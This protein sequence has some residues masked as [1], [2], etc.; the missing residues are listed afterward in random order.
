MNSKEF[1]EAVGGISNENITKYAEVSPVIVKGKN[2]KENGQKKYK[3][4]AVGAAAA[5]MLAAGVFAAVH[6]MGKTP[7]PGQHSVYAPTVIPT[8]NTA[9]EAAATE[10]PP[11]VTDPV[12]E[13]EAISTPKITPDQSTPVPTIDPT[14][15]P[16][17]TPTPTAEPTVTPMPTPTPFQ[18]TTPPA[19]PTPTPTVPVPTDAPI[20]YEFIS[21]EQL[22]NM[23]NNGVDFF[24]EI[25][26]Y[27]KPKNFPSGYSL[28]SIT[29]DNSGI[30]FNYSNGEKGCS[31]LWFWNVDPDEL[32][33]TYQHAPHLEHHGRY[34]RFYDDTAG[35][36]SYCSVVW[37]QDGAAF[38]A[39]V[40]LDFSWDEI[41]YFCNAKL[42][43]I[44]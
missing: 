9:T 15:T 35:T 6:F 37:K 33:A 16:K 40:P 30:S 32:L 39:S 36:P 14:A 4:A 23:I 43:R 22:R 42:V 8:Q 26:Y 38:Y 41:E 20:F 11:V 29:V 44:D 2:T 31:F 25:H 34:F 24:G 5:V 12:K 21:E 17:P 18:A 27:Y 10:R 3:W 13:T 19:Q 7:D 28:T 1:M